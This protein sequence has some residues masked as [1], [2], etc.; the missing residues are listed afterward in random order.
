MEDP[1]AYKKA[2][3]LAHIDAWEL[4]PWAGVEEPWLEAAVEA[5]KRLVEAMQPLL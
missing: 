3:N 5:Y 4:V 2:G 1:P